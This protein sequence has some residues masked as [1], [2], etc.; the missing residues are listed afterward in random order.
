MKKLEK[1][2]FPCFSFLKMLLLALVAVGGAA[3]P[4]C[5]QSTIQGKFT[6]PFEARCGGT[7]LPAGEYKFSI[8]PLGTVKAVTSIESGRYVVLV[9]VGQAVGGRPVAQVTAMA[10]HQDDYGNPSELVF[11]PSNNGM[12]VRSFHLTK[13]G[14]VVD[15]NLSKAEMHARAAE[16]SQSIAAS[17]A[18][19]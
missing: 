13:M 2:S 3:S 8:Q 11:L 16:P 5:A 19:E 17:T 12:V 1:G 6:L 10:S 14:L 15:I 9:T 7:L 4:V 18:A